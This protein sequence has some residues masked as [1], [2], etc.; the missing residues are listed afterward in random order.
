[1]HFCYEACAFGCWDG[2]GDGLHTRPSPLNVKS[3]LAEA[4]TWTACLETPILGASHSL[5]DEF[6]DWLIS[7]SGFRPFSI[8]I[9]LR[10]GWLRCILRLVPV[11]EN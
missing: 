11:I 1:M 8:S 7:V 9:D 6:C 4:E 3:Y 5:R 10:F 2:K